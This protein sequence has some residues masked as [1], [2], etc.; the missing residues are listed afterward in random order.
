MSII[1]SP[2]YVD[3]LEHHIEELKGELRSHK[4]AIDA[5]QAERDAAFAIHKED[6]L[7][8]ISEREALAAQVKGP[9]GFAT[10]KD[11][12]VDERVKRVAAEKRE[13][14]LAAHVERIHALANVAN[15][16]EADDVCNQLVAID[17]ESPA[18]SLARRD[19]QQRAEALEDYC[20]GRY[21]KGCSDY[22]EF[23]RAIDELRRQ[24]EEGP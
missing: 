4:A 13:Q 21:C 23:Q 14:A 20:S 2:A 19:A 15:L 24:A 9:D 16:L 6:Q 22:W 12:A 7:R 1:I 18:T 8:W 3:G 10:W 5:M 11:A 17:D